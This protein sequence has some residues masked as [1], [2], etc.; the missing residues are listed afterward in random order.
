MT[1]PIAVGNEVIAISLAVGVLDI[2]KDEDSY[3][4][5]ARNGESV[6]ELMEHADL[7]TMVGLTNRLVWA[8]D[9]DTVDD[10]LE[11]MRAASEP[12]VAFGI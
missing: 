2:V 9:Q 7:E 6:R 3:R 5:T 12:S 1:S 4:L 8:K 11:Q 10:V